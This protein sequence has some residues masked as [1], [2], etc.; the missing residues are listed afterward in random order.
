MFKKLLLCGLAI[1]TCWMTASVYAGKAEL[2]TYYPAPYGEYSTLNATNSLIVPKKTTTERDAITTSS[3]PPL[4]R[5]MVI[6][7]TDA[8]HNRL[9]VYD[10]GT[11]RGVGGASENWHNVGDPGEPALEN[12]FTQMYPTNVY[13]KVGFFR[14]NDGIV[15]LKGVIRTPNT[16]TLVLRAFQLPVGYRPPVQKSFLVATTRC[17]TSSCPDDWGRITVASGNGSVIPD[18]F[19]LSAGTTSN[20]TAEGVIYLDGISYRVDA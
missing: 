7:N 10:G 11:W 14:D 5:G 6:F 20:P 3:T 4:T 9:E 18:V 1:S 2:T 15:H 13:D 17:T 19:P 12:G 8:G 16:H